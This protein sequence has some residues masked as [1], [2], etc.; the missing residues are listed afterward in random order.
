MRVQ[1]VVQAFCLTVWVIN[2]FLRV[3]GCGWE[4]RS[5]ADAMAVDRSEGRRGMVV[6]V[7]LSRIHG[8]V[9][10][11]AWGFWWGFDD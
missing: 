6:M 7:R 2:V 9:E 11:S 8:E 4:S 1:Q 10:S 3:C 5:T